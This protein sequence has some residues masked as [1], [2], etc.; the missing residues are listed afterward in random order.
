MKYYLALYISISSLFAF[1][2]R[3][4]GDT[5]LIK[6]EQLCKLV[7]LSELLTNLPENMNHITAELGGFNFG[8]HNSE[9][10]H[11]NLLPPGAKKILKQLDVGS[12]LFIHV[13]VK[14]DI[15]KLSKTFCFR[16][17]N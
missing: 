8:K 4:L 1:S 7:F 11:S 13:E 14:N 10:F 5:V 6:K 16:I 12:I 2:Q 15:D 17:I 3:N 9:V